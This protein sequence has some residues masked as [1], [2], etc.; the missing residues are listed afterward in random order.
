M[1]GTTA[2]H[3][4]PA[5]QRMGS[6]RHRQGRSAANRPHQ[7][8]RARSDCRRHTRSIATSAVCSSATTD[9]DSRSMLRETTMIESL[10]ASTTVANVLLR[11]PL[12]AR[13]LVNHRMHCVGCAIA[14]FETLEEA[15]EIYGVS[16]GHL[17]AELN[18]TTKES[19]G[20][21][22]LAKS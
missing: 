4:Q 1:T 14:A 9:P 3:R 15:C 12:A 11:R 7:A 16:L 2:V 6:A 5:S 10:T 13:I 17:L 18:A 8:A 20:P 22:V 21:E 19:P